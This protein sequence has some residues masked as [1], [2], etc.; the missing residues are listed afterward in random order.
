[1]AVERRTRDN[2]RMKRPIRTF[3]AAIAILA[4]SAPALADKGGQGKGGG[5]PD[6]GA[7]HGSSKG[8]G[9]G[10]G[11]ES[12][13]GN[14]PGNSASKGKGAKKFESSDRSAIQSYYRDEYSRGGNCPPG[15]AKKDNGCM[16]PGQA[17]KWNVGSALPSDIYIEPLPSRLRSTLVA[18]MP[19]YDYGYVGGEVILFGVS[20]R[21]VVDFI[22]VY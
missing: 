6:K 12:K 7:S 19:G 11:N 10:G 22:A 2:A 21:I 9:Q 13:G 5:K 17:R 4:L 15:L 18:P 16:P 1:M 8:K 14:G 20:D 3:V